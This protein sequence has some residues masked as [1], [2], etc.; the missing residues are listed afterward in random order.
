MHTSAIT[1]LST[2]GAF[3]KY[4]IFT[5]TDD[6]QQALYQT[7]TLLNLNINKLKMKFGELVYQQ[8]ENIKK[9]LQILII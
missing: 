7:F 2:Y 3:I 9:L 5:S 1:K 8:P 4:F 6:V